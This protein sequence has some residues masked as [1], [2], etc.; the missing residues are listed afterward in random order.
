[1]TGAGQNGQGVD[2]WGDGWSD[3]VAFTAGPNPVAYVPGQIIVQAAAR[4]AVT[5][6]VQELHRGEEPFAEVTFT[7][8]IRETAHARLN[9]RNPLAGYA[10]ARPVGDAP[11]VAR[12]LRSQGVDA[13]L[14]HV[15]FAHCECCGPHPSIGF[16]GAGAAASG[17]PVSGTPVYGT[18]VYGTPVYGTP[19][20]AGMYSEPRRSS[21]FVVDPG[22]ATAMR[23]RLDLVPQHPAPA[24]I[25][26]MVLDVGRAEDQ[27]RMGILGPVDTGRNDVVDVPSAS[28]DHVLDPIAGHTEFIVGLVKS[29]APTAV[30]EARHVLNPPGDGDEST[31]V[32]AIDALGDV[33]PR[34]AVLSLSFGGYTLHQAK[35]MEIAIRDAQSRGWV[36]VASAGNDA[37]CRAPDPA[38]FPDVVAVGALAPDGPASFTNYGPWVWACAPGFDLV[39]TFFTGFDDARMGKFQGWARWSGTSFSTPIVA[40]TLTAWRLAD[41]ERSLADAIA[42][43]ITAPGLLRLRDLGTVVNMV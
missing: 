11:L 18:P 4:D 13:Q 23:A 27:Y 32:A 16:G 22:D 40:A 1:M 26:L 35:V 37:T 41:E 14:N 42:Q 21:A 7:P 31:I 3:R 39:S 28:G 12:E 29:I 25:D 8:L 2:G 38:A 19:A 43:I 10:V 15:F 6:L 34:G 17:M 30:V 24:K 33:R 20:G 9:P 36:V 5:R